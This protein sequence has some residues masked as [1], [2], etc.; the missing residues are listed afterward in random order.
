[1]VENAEE[2]RRPLAIVGVPEEP[3]D[4][5]ADRHKVRQILANLVE[6]APGHLPSGGR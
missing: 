3:L 4:A 1:M 5:S 6:N 2:P